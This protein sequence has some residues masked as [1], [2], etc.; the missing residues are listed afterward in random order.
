MP[1][2]LLE[3]DFIHVQPTIQAP[4]DNATDNASDDQPDGPR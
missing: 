2:Q 4:N 3:S 1:E